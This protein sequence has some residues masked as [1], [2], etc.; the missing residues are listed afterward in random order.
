[1]ALATGLEPVSGLQNHLIFVAVATQFAV[2]RRILAFLPP[3]TGSSQAR[4]PLKSEGHFE[5]SPKQ[6]H[7]TQ[8]GGML[9]ALATGLEPVSGLQHHLI[10]VAIAT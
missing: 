8:M 10:I 4:L 7:T 5:H 2:L 9:L 3:A 6:K 1:M